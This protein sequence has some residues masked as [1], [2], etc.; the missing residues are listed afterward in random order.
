MENFN[1][2]ASAIA[3]GTIFGYEPAAARTLTENLGSASAV[4]AMPPDQLDDLFGPF[5]RFRQE[6]K[7]PAYE[8][9]EKELGRLTS[10]GYQILT[11]TDGDY[12][13]LLKECPDAPVALYVRSDSPACEIFNTVP[14]ISVVGTRDISPYGAERCTA[15][16]AAMATAP[17]KPAI[18]SGL[19]LG[20]DVTAHMA[21]LSHSLPTIAVLP[22]DIETVYP[23]RHRVVA[24]KIASAPGSALI[25]D[26]PSGTGPVPFN[27]L[28]RNR[29]IAGMSQSTILVESKLKGGGTM[30]ARLAAGY[31][32][33]VFCVPGRMDDARS[34]GCNLLI[35]EKVAEPIL[36]ERLLGEAL[37][38]GRFSRRR[39]SDLHE[40][41]RRLYSDRTDARGLSGILDIVEQVR[42]NRGIDI[43]ELSRRVGMGFPDTAAIVGML[44]ND[45]IVCTDLLRR[46]SINLKF[47]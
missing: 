34:Q 19:A 24:E 25:T 1:E 3:L 44:E 12:P 11:I 14:C 18:V 22:T 6:I 13:A 2:K 33:D 29:I 8:K 31:G 26:F 40:E 10:L 43:D 32:R 23:S 36:S 42:S 5:D 9:A 37:G 45:G 39:K 27:F 17:A 15:L 20:V 21:A 38:L 28:R 35:Y 7:L 16:V 47:A 30:T 4:F 41:V 46:C